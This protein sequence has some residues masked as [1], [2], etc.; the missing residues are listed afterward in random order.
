[1]EETG[2]AALYISHDLA[3]VARIAHRVS[4]LDKGRI[5]ESGPVDEVFAAPSH[6][7]TRA[8]LA[9]IPHPRNRIA[10]PEPEMP[11]EVLAV[12]NI[13]VLYGAPGW[14]SRRLGR[15]KAGFYGTKDVSFSVHQGELLGLVGASGSG[16]S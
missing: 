15:N 4:V 14:L 8:L 1:R 3:L 6:P 5:V 16:K 13:S 2:V 11:S 9:A 7:Y 10:V 12:R